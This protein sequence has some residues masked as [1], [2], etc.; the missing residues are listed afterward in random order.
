[1][2]DGKRLRKGAAAKAGGAAASVVSMFGFTWL[3]PGSP[4]LAY[5]APAGPHPW[6]KVDHRAAI[7]SLLHF[8]RDPHDP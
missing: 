6:P 7:S 5:P 4:P 2:R 1:M 8:E 3:F